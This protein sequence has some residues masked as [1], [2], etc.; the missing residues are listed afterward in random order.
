M[1]PGHRA[2]TGFVTVILALLVLIVGLAAQWPLWAW[3]VAAA[4]LGAGTT[5]SL[6]W[7]RRHRPLIPPEF[8]DEPDRP[9][10]PV[11]RWECVVRDVALPSHWDDYDFLFSATVRW[12]PQHPA[13]DPLVVNAGALAVD[14]VL[15]RA[16]QVTER[17]EPH[18]CSLVQHRLH[19]ELATMLPDAGGLVTAMAENVRLRL[20]DADRERLAKLATVR[21]DEAVWEHER[22]YEQNKR[23]Y[24]GED[25]LKTPG[26]AVVWWLAKNDEQVDKTVADIGLLAELASAAHDQPVPAD[27][28]R[29]VPGLAAQPPAPEPEE[30]RE[31][32]QDRAAP[33]TPD[34]RVDQL[35]ESIGITEDDPRFALFIGR[36]AE[37]VKLAGETEMAEALEHR[38]ARLARENDAPD[39][40]GP[41][42]APADGGD[43]PDEAQQPG[44]QHP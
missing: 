1:H 25:V 7:E 41:D 42:A 39:G 5:A 14:A 15:Q 3:P 33:R 34:E 9:I 44:D 32:A 38:H 17:F 19:A 30:E 22:K 6:V 31:P 43:G 20:D 23:A 28:R 29:F 24:L 37:D 36:L 18:R 27:F 2:V 40:S 26:S 8:L 35:L 13:S 12:V 10:P 16:R 21:K 11:D 4:V